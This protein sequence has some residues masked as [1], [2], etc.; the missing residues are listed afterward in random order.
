MSEDSNTTLTTEQVQPLWPADLLKS[1]M[2]EELV[3]STAGW[4]RSLPQRAG[5]CWPTALRQAHS[6]VLY[7]G[8]AYFCHL[9]ASFPGSRARQWLWY[10]WKTPSTSAPFGVWMDWVYSW[11]SLGHASSKDRHRQIQTQ[12]LKCKVLAKTDRKV[13][14]ICI[15]WFVCCLI[16]GFFV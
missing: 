3:C 8:G 2:S 12:E 1:S 10:N 6:H 16:Q 11:A 7:C 15:G 5:D 14:L 9:S 13:W 4:P